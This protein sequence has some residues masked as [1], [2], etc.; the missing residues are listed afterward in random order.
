M[1]KSKPTPSPTESSLTRRRLS[2]QS[3]KPPMG[4]SPSSKSPSLI[5]F[6]ESTLDLIPEK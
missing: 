3:S 6:R 1:A 5:S 2:I 4:I